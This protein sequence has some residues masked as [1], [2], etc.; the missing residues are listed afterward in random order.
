VS[1][2]LTGNLLKLQITK[3]I[4]TKEFVNFLCRGN[5]CIASTHKTEDGTEID[6]QSDGEN[7]RDRERKREIERDRERQR[8]KD[9]DWHMEKDIHTCKNGQ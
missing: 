6:R 9:L 7:G 3:N 8:E 1:S 2:F 4:T 5:I